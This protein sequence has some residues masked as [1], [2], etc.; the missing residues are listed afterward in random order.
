[1]PDTLSDGAREGT[2]PPKVKLSENLVG[3]KLCPPT[4]LT[5]D[6]QEV[7]IFSGLRAQAQCSADPHN[8]SP[9]LASEP[10]TW[11][12]VRQRIRPRGKCSCDRASRDSPSQQT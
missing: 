2:H 8:T 11:E 4:R 12:S 5:A 10:S 1:M 9:S 6:A 7:Q 3:H